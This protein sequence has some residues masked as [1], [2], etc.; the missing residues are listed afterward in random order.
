MGGF[1]DKFRKAREKKGI[2]L[3]DVSNATKI[4]ARM[5]QAI[6]EENFDQLPGGVFN[7]GFIR[8]YAKH[9]GLDPEDAVNDYLAC[10]RQAQIDS[11]AGWDSERP[12]PRAASVPKSNAPSIEKPAAQVPTPAEAEELPDLQLPR[13]EHI[14]KKKEYLERPASGPPWLMMAVVLVIVLG[15]LALWMRHSRRA[16]NAAS[17]ASPPVVTTVTASAPSQ[18]NVPAAS[19]ATVPSVKVSAAASKPQL[20]SQS[21]PAPRSVAVQQTTTAPDT[22]QSSPGRKSDGSARPSGATVSPTSS[23]PA[24]NLSLVVRAAE[25]SWISVSADGQLVT[26]E[27]LIAPAAT[28]FHATREF[29]VRVGNAAGVTFLWNGE[30]IPPQGAESEVKTLV[31]DAQGMRAGTSPQAAQN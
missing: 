8:A 24:T 6:E 13:A 2:S 7:K 23:T 4:T 27:T 30:E 1:G 22:N 21:T 3:D 28:S 25:T 14:R 5:L 31:F 11:H 10:L 26:Q 17:S 16:H 15:A 18:S 29:V 19:P 20:A 9:L 12:G